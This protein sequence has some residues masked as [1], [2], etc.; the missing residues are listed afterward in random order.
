[1]VLK[2]TLIARNLFYVTSNLTAGQA[3]K[4][5]VKLDKTK[6]Y[7][8]CVRFHFVM[9][10][11]IVCLPA[12]IHSWIKILFHKVSC[13]QGHSLHIRLIIL[14]SDTPMGYILQIRN[15]GRGQKA[16]LIKSLLS[17]RLHC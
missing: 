11:S 15:V 6:S 5:L 12:Q 17:V 14:R 2:M 13:L 9:F 8:F 16:D 4:L 3:S 1:M 7:I 10:S